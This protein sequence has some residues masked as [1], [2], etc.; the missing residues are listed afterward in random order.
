MRLLNWNT[1]FNGWGD[2]LEKMDLVIDRL[3]QPDWDVA[4]LQE[5]SKAFGRRLAVSNLAECMA[6]SLHD[7]PESPHGVAVLTREGFLISNSQ[8]LPEAPVECNVIAAVVK[9]GSGTINVISCHVPN[10]AARPMS[11]KDQS[12]IALNRFL[13]D[14][15]DPAV[16]GMDSNC[17][18]N[19]EWRSLELPIQAGP[20]PPLERND[21]RFVPYEF[22]STC[23]QHQLRDAFLEWLKRNPE[24]YEK[25][26]VENPFGPLAVSYVRKRSKWPNDRIDR[27]LVSPD[28]HVSNCWYDYDGGIKAGSDHATVHADLALRKV[29]V[30]ENVHDGLSDSCSDLTAE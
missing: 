4:T 15:S 3:R 13:G 26:R 11:I 19:L 8:A 14:L 10:T 21:R 18:E 22:F 2:S 30:A 1:G 6:W 25:R 5:V 27:I 23:P 24:D 20:R 7:S 12:Y 28:F 16:L 9:S 29:D 17:W